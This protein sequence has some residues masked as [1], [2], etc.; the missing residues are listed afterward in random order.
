MGSTGWAEEFASSLLKRAVVYLNVDV[1][2][3]GR[4]FKVA[5][6]PSLSTL[7]QKTLRKVRDPDSGKLLSEVWDGGVGTLGSGSDYT[8]FLD[9]L[10][11]T[12]LD[13]RFLPAE[14]IQYG[15]YH[16][17]Y[18]SYHWVATQ[19]DPTFGY[20]KA[21]AQI[22]GLMALQLSTEE[23]LPLDHTHQAKALKQYL[24]HVKQ[25]DPHELLQFAG[26][27]RAIEKYERATTSVRTQIQNQ[28]TC[29]AEIN[30]RLGFTERFFLHPK[31]LPQRKW[32]KHVLQSPGLYLGYAAEVF[33]GIT[34]AINDHNLPT[35]QSEI[36]HAAWC[37]KCVSM[38]AR[39]SSI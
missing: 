1:G 31:G 12:S 4:R 18:D 5:A 13:M 30:E 25:L 36:N 22:W 16:S 3:S 10:G 33:P 2:V 24:A 32:Y 28:G 8:V 34:Q 20:H 29:S 19:A 27:R 9:H 17:V 35:A 37:G 14:S 6:T 26:L 11:I 39:L 15:V 38:S 21:M 7:I 23:V